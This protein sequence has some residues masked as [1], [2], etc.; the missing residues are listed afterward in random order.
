MKLQSVTQIISVLI[1]FFTSIAIVTGVWGWDQMERPYKI[2][3]EYNNFNN[4][5]NSDVY[6]KLE[7]YLGT[8]NASFLKEAESSLMLLSSS[9]LLWLSDDE[10][11]IIGAAIQDVSSNIQLVREAG[12]LSA[13]PD[14]LLIHNELDRAS[15]ITSLIG[16]LN[17][18]TIANEFKHKYL[19]LFSKTSAGLQK[20]SYLRQKYIHTKNPTIK[21]NLILQND[22]LNNLLVE[23]KRLPDLGVIKEPEE[24]TFDDEEINL[25]Q[26]GIDNLSSLTSRYVKELNNTEVMQARLL[27]SRD[28]LK[29]SLDRLRSTF[30]S[31]S[32]RVEVIKSNITEQVKWMVLISV[33]IIV[34]LLVFSFI[35]QR[36]TFAF[37]SQLI[38]FFGS[39]VKGR[40]DEEFSSSANFYEIHTVKTTGIHLQNYLKDM[41][42][43]LQ[44][45]AENVLESS[46][47]FQRVSDQAFGLA[48]LQS[49]K[50][51]AT[52]I[53]I[54]QL[55]ESFTEVA[56][57][58]ASAS[59]SA[60]EASESTHQANQKLLDATNK[61]NQLSTDILSLGDLMHRLQQ[62]SNA[63]ESVLDVIKGVADQTN[64]L[65]LNA[66]IEAARAGEQGRG[67]AVVA[68]EVRQL[69][70]RTAQSTEEIQTII[71]NLSITAKEATSAV[72]VQSD[73]AIDCVSKTQDA[74]NALKPVVVAV[75]TI[76]DYNTGIASATEQQ[77]VTAEEVA[78]ST[79]EIQNHAQ[80][81]SQNMHQ[82]HHA[83]ESLSQVSE[84]L[85]LLVK[86]LKQGD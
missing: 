71:A 64:L 80:D 50:T 21:E 36:M 14:E 15:D 47:D 18:S 61:T 56:R 74:Q 73:S 27:E 65:A 77:S 5:I 83:S 32:D 78:R 46:R 40:F 51:E 9:K 52:A 1:I 48:N 20:L 22:R 2:N 4:V 6:I 45:Q 3:Q 25:G 86:R 11:K 10:N 28:A 44:I 19:Q 13:N 85:T 43:Q 49:Q 75:D 42:D 7:R 76:T 29:S 16:Y 53:S 68:D 62:D 72:Q 23:L 66:A 8:G 54:N 58:A 12:K 34:L 79:G 38:P 57:N 30:D 17:Q 33:S 31:Y 39:M 41:I 59:V 81:V 37:L 84:A 24:D 26:D 82:V 60:Q 35:I 63:I 55:S 69:A 67:F 70:Q